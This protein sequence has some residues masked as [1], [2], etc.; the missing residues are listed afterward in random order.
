MGPNNTKIASKTCSFPQR[1][2]QPKREADLYI[3][4]CDKQNV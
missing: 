3:K 2:S 1:S 4:Y